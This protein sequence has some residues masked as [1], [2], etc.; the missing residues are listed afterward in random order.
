MSA[1]GLSAETA[2]RELVARILGGDRQAFAAVYDRYADRLFDF[3]Y[4]TTRHR[5]DA[6]DAVADTFVACA[7]RLT[8]LRDPDRLRPWLYAITRNACF[9]QLSGRNREAYDGEEQLD[10]MVDHGATP[11][12]EAERTAAATLVWDAAEGL[13]DR[14]RA[15]LDL[16]VRQGL[17]GAELGEAIGADANHAY[18]LVHRMRAQLERAIGA[19]LVA[20]NGRE[21]CADLD[22]LLSDW[23]GRYTPLIRK[24]IARHTERCDTCGAKKSRLVA[25]WALLAA[26]PVFAAPTGLRESVLEL[27]W[28]TPATSEG[29][30]GEDAVGEGGAGTTPGPH[31]SPPPGTPDAAP[32]TAPGESGGPGGMVMAAIIGAGTIILAL[33]LILIATFNG[34]FGVA[35]PVPTFTVSAERPMFTPL[36]RPTPTPTAEPGVIALSAERIDLGTTTS[37]GTVTVTNDGGSPVTITVETTEPWLDVDAQTHTIA[38]TESVE[39]DID[40]DRSNLAPG[41]HSGHVQIATTSQALAVAV[42][43]TVPEP[44][45]EPNPRPDPE[46]K[47]EPEP[48][49]EPPV[50][51][52]TGP[53]L[54]D[55]MCRSEGTFLLMQVQ[56]AT[57]APLGAVT[58]HWSAQR[59]N[60][61]TTSGQ[62]EMG[63]NAVAWIGDAGPLVTG[64]QAVLWATGVDPEGRTVSGD[65]VTMTVPKC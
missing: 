54:L 56:S 52:L 11:E 45:P 35:N 25:P 3:A 49:P 58:L 14:D 30:T 1:D 48:E 6:A 55:A 46:P 43:L 53:T 8:Q 32:G 2:D 38:P 24:R 41:P 9:R 16:N 15:L 62:S 39:L 7:E 28:P 42:V 59:S 19:L 63:A 31:P 27:A 64:S 5:E 22:A 33:I 21:D 65:S 37:S 10:A 13:S 29:R 57:G 51:R 26:I 18:V 34:W 20:R 61:Q 23:D 40:A 44:E 47:P 36:P 4:A 12:S 17:E 60:G 50:L